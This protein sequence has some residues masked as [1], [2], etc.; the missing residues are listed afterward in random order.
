[1]APTSPTRRHSRNESFPIRNERE[2]I[3]L[4][5]VLARRAQWPVYLCLRLSR[6]SLTP[7]LLFF[8]FFSSR[9]PDLISAACF[10]FAVLFSVVHFYQLDRTLKIF[11]AD[12][13]HSLVICLSSGKLSV[14]NTIFLL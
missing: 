13:N 5:H 1:M 12:F 9:F 4:S 14:Q 10:F 2:L 3:R 7:A 8:L 11:H 6:R